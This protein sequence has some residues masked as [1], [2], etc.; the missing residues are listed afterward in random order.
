MKTKKLQIAFLIVVPMIVI[1]GAVVSF[2]W[3]TSYYPKYFE[4]KHSELFK[5]IEQEKQVGV[6]PSA[7]AEL[8]KPSSAE[9]TGQIGDT[10]GGTLAPVI[11]VAAA[12][13]TF[14]AFWVQLWANLQ[15]KNYIRNQRF[16]DTFF[17]LIDTHER[18]V[19][20]ID[21][22]DDKDMTRVKATAR[23]TYKYMHVELVKLTKKKTDVEIIKASYHNTQEKF[24][25]DL[26][27]YFRFVYHILKFIKRS[28]LSIEE[29]YTY[30]SM[31]RGMFSAHEL[32]LLFYNGLHPF[33]AKLKPLL[34]EFSFLKNIDDSL[35]L[36]EDLWN[37]YDPLVRAGSEDRKEFFKKW[38]Q[39]QQG[40]ERKMGFSL[41]FHY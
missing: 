7:N 11:A 18:M 17:R 22:R 1:I 27:H 41:I 4:A 2:N 32:S 26:H 37:E 33:G 13:L 8:E 19:D 31:F 5:Q 3:V 14:L 9:R 25:H 38:K 35:V 15:Q 34:E 23:E 28:E 6:K 20:A 40:G 39:K 29:K 36:N 10:F 24:K 16:E 30:S 12:V 21:L